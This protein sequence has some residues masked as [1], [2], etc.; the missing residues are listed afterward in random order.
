V[1]VSSWAG[2]KDKMGKM[3][4]YSEFGWPDLPEDTLSKDQQGDGMMI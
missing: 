3:K 4:M 2:H 1:V